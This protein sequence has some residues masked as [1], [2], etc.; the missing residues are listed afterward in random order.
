VVSG[1]DRQLRYFWIHNPAFGRPAEAIL[2]RTDEDLFDPEEAR[3]LTAIKRSVLATETS[4]RHTVAVHVN[5]ERRVYDVYLEPMRDEKGAV[6]GVSGV[7]T[8]ITPAVTGAAV[9][10]D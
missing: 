2:G 1:Q 9:G 4:A 6:I 3:R 10:L 8:D 7:H 5:H